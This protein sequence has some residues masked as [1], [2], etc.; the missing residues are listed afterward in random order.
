MIKIIYTGKFL[1]DFKKYSKSGI[2]FKERLNE[3]IEILGLGVSLPEKFKGHKLNG[4]WNGAKNNYLDIQK[5][6][7]DLCRL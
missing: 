3:V 1:R 4:K 2:N 7:I 6:V 5:S